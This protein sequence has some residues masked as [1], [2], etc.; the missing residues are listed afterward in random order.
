MQRLCSVCVW[1]FV[2]V[3]VSVHACTHTH[4]LTHALGCRSPKNFCSAS[5]SYLSSW[6]QSSGFWL[7]CMLSCAL[8]HGNL[9]SLIQLHS[10]MHA[11]APEFH[12]LWGM[13][14]VGLVVWSSHWVPLFSLYFPAIVYLL[15]CLRSSRFLLPSLSFFL[16]PLSLG[17]S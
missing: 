17:A 9:I 6:P 10:Q 2:C 3:C 13:V 11:S 8:L 7:L 14:L 15:N 5:S 12:R 16:L 1:E 4:T